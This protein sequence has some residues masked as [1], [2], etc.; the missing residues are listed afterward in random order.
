MPLHKRQTLRWR[1]FD[2]VFVCIWPDAMYLV[3]DEDGIGNRR[4]SDITTSS[5]EVTRYDV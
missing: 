5:T 1:W 4:D 3:E 2:T